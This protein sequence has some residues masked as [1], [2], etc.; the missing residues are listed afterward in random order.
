MNVAEIA[1]N[2]QHLATGVLRKCERQIHA[3]QRFPILRVRTRDRNDLERLLC[4]RLSK[5]NLQ[6][7][8]LLTGE[9]EFVPRHFKLFIQY[10]VR[11]FGNQQVRRRGYGYNEALFLHVVIS[12]QEPDRPNPL[13][14]SEN[15][16]QILLLGSGE[17]LNF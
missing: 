2:D 4:F 9:R 16:L 1:I 17:G 7:L 12:D 8:E 5:L 10:R 11:D 15:L 6:V 3:D 13:E 14:N